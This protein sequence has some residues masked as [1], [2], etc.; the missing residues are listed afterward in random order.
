MNIAAGWALRLL[1]GL[2]LAGLLAPLTLMLPSGMQGPTTV[3]VT[4]AVGVLLV[5][6]VAGKPRARS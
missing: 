3:L 1:G 2:L 4:A 6:A 5:L